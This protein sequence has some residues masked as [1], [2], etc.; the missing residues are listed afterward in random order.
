MQDRT[1]ICE[2]T[3]KYL[4]TGCACRETINTEFSLWKMK[5]THNMTV[6]W[7]AAV[8]HLWMV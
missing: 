7:S 2:W 5:L 6:K 4:T 3:D 1:F 8:C